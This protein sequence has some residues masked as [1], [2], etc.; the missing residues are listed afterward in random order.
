MTVTNLT[1]AAISVVPHI[2]LG[3]TFGSFPSISWTGFGRANLTTSTPVHTFYHQIPLSVACEIYHNT[4]QFPEYTFAASEVK[5]YTAEFELLTLLA[6][7]GQASSIPTQIAGRLT[8]FGSGSRKTVALRCTN[9]TNC[10]RVDG[11][12]E[13]GPDPDPPPPPEPEPPVD[14]DCCD[15]LLWFC[16]DGVSVELP[17]DGGT[18]LWDVSACCDTCESATLEIVLSCENGIITLQYEY[19]C[20]SGVPEY[21][22]ENTLM[23]LFCSSTDPRIINI[24][25]GCFLQLQVSINDAGCE[26]CGPSTTTPPPP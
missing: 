2:M 11:D 9:G 6:A 1:A 10:R 19:I 7:Y 17:V 13:P 15:L 20:D 4:V 3:K 22:V 8:K 24:N 12:I 16:L 26:E 21:G 18:Y 5:V 14:P 25:E 23:S